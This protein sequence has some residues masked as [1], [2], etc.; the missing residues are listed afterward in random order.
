MDTKLKEA[1]SAGVFVEFRD[2]R[3]N[4]VGRAV[5]TDWRGRPVPGAGDRICSQA[6]LV[7]TQQSR[8]LTGTVRHRQFD[9]QTDEYGEPVIWVYLIVDVAGAPASALRRPGP[10]FSAN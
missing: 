10:G 1:M 3:D 9:L 5:F 2:E 7:A 6:T 8:K 4:T